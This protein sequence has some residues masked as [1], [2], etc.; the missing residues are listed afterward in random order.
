LDQYYKLNMIKLDTNKYFIDIE[1]THY[2]QLL[3]EGK[4]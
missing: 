3:E 2:S 4:I 1:S